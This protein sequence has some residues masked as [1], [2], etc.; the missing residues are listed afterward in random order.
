MR[1]L[2]GNLAARAELRPDDIALIFASPNSAPIE[3]TN[4]ALVERIAKYGAF[5][6]HCGIRPGHVIAVMARRPVE[7]ALTV[8]AALGIGAVPTVV[9]YPSP[10]QDA[11][12]FLQM[13]NSVLRASGT[14]WLL[15][16]A[17][18]E[19]EVEAG[20][21]SIGMDCEG[22]R[23]P[24]SRELMSFKSSGLVTSG[25][26][27]MFLQFS[28]GTLGPRKGA[29][30]SHQMLILHSEAFARSILL[31]SGDRIA[32]WAP[33]YHDGG[34][35]RC[36]LSPLCVGA[37][38]V[39]LDPFEW[40]QEPVFLLRTM[41][42]L[43]A[44]YCYQ[45]NFAYAFTAARVDDEELNGIDLAHVRA[46]LMGGEP[47]RLRTVEEFVRRFYSIG[48]RRKQLQVAYG[49]AEN[50]CAVCQTPVGQEVRFDRFDQTV[51]EQ[52]VAQGGAEERSE[53]AYVAVASCGFPVDGVEVRIAG[54]QT[55][56]SLGEI[57]VRS[58]FQISQY[59]NALET[60]AASPLTADGWVR[61]GDLGYLFEGELFVC[62]RSKDLLI[63]NGVNVFPTD[64]EEA[65]Q[66]VKGCKPGR[67]VVFGV[68]DAALGTESMV[69]G[70]E[71]VSVDVDTAQ[72]T[73]E[74][75]RALQSSF[76]FTGAQIW[77][78]RPGT[79]RKSTSGKLSRP[80][81]RELFLQEQSVSRQ[82][83]RSDAVGILHDAPTLDY[84]SIRD[85]LLEI[86]GDVL[87]GAVQADQDLFVEL[88]VDSISAARAAGLIHDAFGTRLSLEQILACATVAEQVDQILQ[89]ADVGDYVTVVGKHRPMTPLIL[90]HP[91]S[92]HGW[93]YLPLLRYIQNRPLIL[94][95]SPAWNDPA[96]LFDSIEETADH[97]I[98]GIKAVRPTGPYLL[99]G[100]SFGGSVAF[101]IAARLDEAGEEVLGVTLFDSGV[102]TSPRAALR[103]RLIR[104][105]AHWA[106]RFPTISRHVPVVKKV[107]EIEDVATR[108][109]VA[110]RPHR[111]NTV[112]DLLP[113]VRYLLPNEEI[114][115]EVRKG[116]LDSFCDWALPLIVE[117]FGLAKGGGVILGTGVELLHQARV[118]ANNVRL[119]QQYVRRKRSRCR[120][121]YF[122]AS[123]DD[124]AEKWSAL[125]DSPAQVEK[126]ELQ[127]DGNKGVHLSMFMRENIDVFGPRLREILDSI[128]G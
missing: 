60:D 121:V 41:H 126:F 123:K 34:F 64:V 55:E 30:I 128:D 77:I 74:V 92:G 72:L 27:T 38:P 35:V 61:T 108:L 117:K 69:I 93:I 25:E 125:C 73:I 46:F 3:F 114:P 127:R 62:G 78:C 36:F 82:R 70:V 10:K 11:N 110:L 22:M 106:I 37:V 31:G 49:M 57:E 40:L 80:A 103:N 28:S 85:T 101:E 96:L 63:I 54:A 26:G 67:V 68:E 1:S 79:L 18:F 102:V 100:Y 119:I 111:C 14:R 58:P 76:G 91:A 99:G 53:R 47:A 6:T 98:A 32:A 95:G 2:V 124:R 45:P 81:N 112:R 71:P 44:S 115:A 15:Y 48:V 39:L 120:L 116:T 75:R 118:R 97:Y 66:M 8:L 17:D 42:E 43:H 24:G 84:S 88:G 65:V 5:L 20:K 90:V 29:A 9:S 19:A 94:I 107:F 13:L 52:D 83:G 7:Q 33:L 86:W 21:G 59:L 104:A 122:Q 56:R 113:L 23:I 50:T 12:A 89:G 87:Q 105:I 4:R 16:S 109:N 51:L